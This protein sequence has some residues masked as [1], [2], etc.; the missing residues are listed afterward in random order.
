MLKWQH[1]FSQ[2]ILRRGQEYFRKNKVRSLIKDGD[3]YYATVEG[4]EEYSVEIRTSHD[5]VTDMLC[6]CP[7]AEG[8]G[9]CKHMAAALYEISARDLP[10]TW[11]SARQSRSE[12][13]P[14]A[15]F[16]DPSH[17]RYYKAE[18]FGRDLIVCRNTYDRAQ[19]L[20]RDPSF[21]IQIR[22]VYSQL[23]GE[24]ALQVWIDPEQDDGR[25]ASAVVNR[26][27]VERMACYTRGC[28]ATAFGYLSSS[29]KRREP[30]EHVLALLLKLAETLKEEEIGD[31][32]DPAALRALVKYQK[33]MCSGKN[34]SSDE[35][36]TG[37]VVGIE[38]RLED[39]FGAFRLT[40]RI[41]IGGKLYVLRS[42]RDLVDAVE[43]RK[44]FPLGKTT[45]LRF[46]ADRISDEARPYYEMIKRA[47]LEQRHR[48][49]TAP[50]KNAADQQ[51]LELY[52]ALLDEFYAIAE[53][54]HAVVRV[55]DSW[56]PLRLKDGGT[57]A[58]L[59]LQK[60]TDSDGTFHGVIL[61]GRLPEL[62]DGMRYRYYREGSSLVRVKP[63]D[64]E[65]LVPLMEEAHGGSLE[66]HIGRSYLTD[67]YYNILPEIASCADVIEPD[68]EE[69]EVYLPPEAGFAFYLDAE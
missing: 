24:K 46:S 48:E 33:R 3:V 64:Y 11:R 41:G 54:H 65:K 62:I 68:R 66:M 39:S 8:N 34:D 23:Q 52:G 59:T 57:P 25:K 14:F 42:I 6:S 30:C 37:N 51:A 20:M 15:D 50:S 1:L 43:E 31:A 35:E 56:V 32:T 4:T 58:L 19:E 12:I 2:Q 22:E 13:F 28:R 67:F 9:N 61:S 5:A 27:G 45:V 49:Q 60:E 18:Q 40:F 26:D 38:P 29:G 16:E 36:E 7:Y 55:N 69:I 47:V 17:Y 53:E 44:E 63:E 10:G 21:S